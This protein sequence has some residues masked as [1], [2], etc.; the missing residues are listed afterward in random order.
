MISKHTRFF[1][2]ITAFMTAILSGSAQAQDSSHSFSNDS[3]KTP[4]VQKTYKE[5]KATFGKVPSFFSAFP[6]EGVA[7]AWE[8]FK[9]TDLNPKGAIPSEY[10]ELIG[11]AVSSQ[12][13]CKYCVTFHT[14]SA[15]QNGI[16]NRTLNEAITLSALT[17]HWSTW[18]NGMQIDSLAFRQEVA[19]IVAHAKL[20][21]SSSK[22]AL[23]LP[24][25]SPPIIV[26]DAKSAYQDMRNE[27]GIIPQFFS[28]YPESAIVGAWKTYKNVQMSPNTALAPKHKE[29][30]GLAVSSQ[31]PCHYCTLMHTEIARLHGA[32]EAEIGEAVMTASLTRQWSTIL[33]GLNIPDDQFKRDTQDMLRFMNKQRQT[34]PLALRN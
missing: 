24:L 10:R 31:I 27:L 14:L 17:R 22:N 11:L 15:K 18:L 1:L 7:A 9:A 3:S 16:S 29:L 33:N 23:G 30:I 4:A 28:L 2:I 32:S 19:Q 8:H 6:H 26:V 25:V 21:S 13:P 34:Q 20:K 5:I 12:I